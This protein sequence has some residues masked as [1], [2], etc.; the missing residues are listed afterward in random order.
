MTNI[1]TTSPAA[2]D[3]TLGE[4]DTGVAGEAA[5]TKISKKRKGALAALGIALLILALLF[6]WYLMNRKPLSELPG[7]GSTRMPSYQFSIYGVTKP[8]G[9]AVSATGDRIYVTQ[10]D[11]APEERLSR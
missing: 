11:G 1:D 4:I 3:A 9:V 2:P 10:S 5:S 7:L 6:A 8:L